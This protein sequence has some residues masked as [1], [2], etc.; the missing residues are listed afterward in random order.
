[1]KRVRMLKRMALSHASLNN[2]QQVRSPKMKR[3]LLKQE[4]S[5]NASPEAIWRAL[6][7]PCCIAQWHSEVAQV[8]MEGWDRN[9]E[10]PFLGAYRTITTRTGNT[11]SQLITEWYPGRILGYK[12]LRDARIHGNQN[13][14][15]Q[16]GTFN[17]FFSNP[18]TEL[19]WL[20]YI[21][22]YDDTKALKLID[23]LNQVY[24]KSLVDLKKFI[25]N[26]PRNP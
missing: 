25:E 12:V 2:N 23:Y 16:I 21:E 3:V 6:T 1:M 8:T 26:S 22:I 10:T 17:L 14:R 4:I 9:D 5:I 13:L 11:Q 7:C 15:L 24:Y 20:N 19:Q 18:E